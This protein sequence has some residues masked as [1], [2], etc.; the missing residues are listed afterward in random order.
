MPVRNKIYIF[1]IAVVTVLLFFSIHA[2]SQRKR[3][4]VSRIK[5]GGDTVSPD[6]VRERTRRL[7]LVPISDI[8]NLTLDTIAVTPDTI[9]AAIVNDTIKGD[10]ISEPIPQKD[11]PLTNV[12][13][14]TAKDSMVFSKGNMAYMFGNS[15]VN[16]ED[17][18]LD[19]DEIR[20]ALDSSTVYAIG[21]P[22]TSG[23]IIGNPIF[24]DPSGEY[25]SETMKYNFKSKKGYITNVVTQ[26]GEG[27]LVGGRTKKNDDGDF[28]LCEGKYTTCDNHDHPHFYMQLT[29][30]K[31]RPGKNVVTGPAYMVMGGVPLP[32]AIPFGFFPFTSKYSSGIIMPTIGEESARGFYLRNGGYYFAI[33]DN[34]DLALTGE[35]YTKGSW[36]LQG[37]SAY[38][39]RYKFSGYVNASYLTT[40]LGDKGMPDYQKQTNFKLIWQ[41]RQDQKA[42]PNMS[43]SASVNFSTSGY[44]RNS[45]NTYYNASE[46]TQNTKSSTVNFTYT[47]PNAPVSL[48]STANITQRTKDSTLAV[49]F[50]DFTVN[51]N[52]IYPF[53]RKKPVGKERW[54]EKISFNYTGIFRNTITTKQDLFFKSSLL[55]DW[56]NGMQ[57]NIPVSATFSAFKYLNITPSFSFTDRMYT[58]RIMKQW[59]PRAS[60]VVNDTLY[61][62]Y[63]VYNYSGSVTLQTK[64]YGFFQPLKWMG[65]KKIKM[66]RHVFTPNV[67]VT[68][69]PDFGASRFGFWQRYTQINSDGSVREVRYSPFS[70][71]IFGTAPQGKQGT[72]NFGINNNIEMKV[73][74]D[75]DTTGV[76][77]ISLIENLSANWGYNMAADSMNWSNINMGVLIRLFKNFNLQAN[78]TFDT[79]TYQ[80][81]SYGNP[82]RVNVPRWKVGKGLGRL[83]STGTS[84]SY[85]FNNSTF[86]KLFKKDKDKKEETNT[87]TRSNGEPIVDLEELAAVQAELKAKQKEDG[88]KDDGPEMKN[89]YMVWKI[90]WSLSVNYSINY[91]YGTFNKEKLEYNGKITQNLSFSG[92]IQPTKNWIFTFSTSY[93][94]DAKRLAYMSCGITRDLHCWSMSC[95]FVPV[96]PYQ[97]YNFHISVKSS[98]LRDLKYE[99]SSSPYNT[100]NWY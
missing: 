35:I 44:D 77:K 95:D 81:N 9:I 6:S 13:K 51:V 91:G 76:R 42:N 11:S 47:F 59:D 94:F 3:I 99:K 88:D 33:S 92:N 82:V 32:L 28:Y 60:A 25:E 8:S 50:P 100:E 90:P 30:A 87:N 74:S 2:E 24:K 1:T 61:G 18:Q 4:T 15:R 75:R 31:M 67:S 65:G 93:D 72:V 86:Q 53:K 96:G 52:R 97:S 71:G 5:G 83:S 62:F 56:Q 38:V 45:L 20:M 40:I 23:D 27:Y 16:Y 85:T 73:N 17:I 39:K 22:D 12:V 43:F 80:L 37:Q 54:Y 89:G 58:N 26:Q 57:H 10:S 41:H 70:N 21:R 63:N 29:K 19:A 36:G 98:L 84:F 69:A 68:G 64:L 14:Y 48:S 79:Y 7:D 34:I 55:K 78:F 46:F 66:I 49:S